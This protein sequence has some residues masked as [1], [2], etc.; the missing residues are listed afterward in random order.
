MTQAAS[1]LNLNI[2]NTTTQTST[3]TNYILCKCM[4]FESGKQ[5]KQYEMMKFQM[6]TLFIHADNHDIMA[7]NATDDGDD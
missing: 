7:D 3:T 6:K 1:N 4:F 5:N 2:E